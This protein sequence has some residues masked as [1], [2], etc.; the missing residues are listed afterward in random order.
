[1]P[2]DRS[3]D[4]PVCHGEGYDLCRECRGTAMGRYSDSC[5]RCGLSGRG[6]ACE[7]C[8]GRSVLTWEEFI[9]WVEQQSRLDH[10]AVSLL[11]DEI[12]ALEKE[13]AP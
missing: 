6:P 2:R 4:C 1:M 9:A 10:D 8:E 5:P 13:A 7:T 11:V 3:V 12:L